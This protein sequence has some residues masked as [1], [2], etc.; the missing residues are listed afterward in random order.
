MRK[1]MRAVALRC[2]PLIAQ[3]TTTRPS[4]LQARLNPNNGTQGLFPGTSLALA[5][6][7]LF[8]RRST[9]SSGA[10]TVVAYVNRDG[11]VESRPASLRESLADH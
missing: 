8:E 2:C 3:F 6:P 1:S 10:L 4:G 5:V 11:A 9:P 7:S